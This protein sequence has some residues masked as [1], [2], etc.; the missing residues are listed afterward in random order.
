V[1]VVNDYDLLLF[2]EELNVYFFCASVK[3]VLYKLKNRNKLIGY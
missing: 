2:G 3:G 1:A